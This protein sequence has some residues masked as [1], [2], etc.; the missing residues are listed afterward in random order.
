VRSEDIVRCLAAQVRTADQRINSSY[1]QLIAKGSPDE[2]ARLRDEERDWIKR[3]DA[4]CGISERSSD[5]EQWYADLLVDYRTAVCAT[6]YAQDRAAEL[7][8]RLSGAVAPAA[9]ARETRAAAAPPGSEMS[10]Y[11]VMSRAAVR[12]GKWY[13]EVTIDPVK[14]SA[15][16]ATAVWWGC[17]WEHTSTGSVTRVHAEDTAAPILHAAI[18][19]DLDAGM[20]YI[21]KEGAWR[22]GPPGSSGG[23]DVT[24]GRPHRCGIETTVPVGDLLA[25]RQLK[26]NFGD[27]PFD[28]SLPEGY[29]PLASAPVT[30]SMADR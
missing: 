8:R 27:A 26:L 22:T 16:A 5:R 24:P 13:F 9:A 20:V 28:Y 14:I 3:R 12:S 30:A 23:I 1:R 18:A 29:R 7:E 19:L 11:D 17:R 25:S 6:H 4:A 15:T 2:R 21:R 10:M